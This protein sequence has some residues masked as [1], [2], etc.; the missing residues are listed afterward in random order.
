M[1]YLIRSPYPETIDLPAIVGG[2]VTYG[3]LPSRACTLPSGL[4]NGDFMV[5]VIWQMGSS[6]NV[7][8]GLSGWSLY[9]SY[10]NIH[11][12]RIQVYTKTAS[13]ESNPTIVFASAQY[14]VIFL[15]AYRN[16]KTGITQNQFN[17][18]TSSP[19]TT[20]S[21]SV[22]KDSIVIVGGSGAREGSSSSFDV[23]TLDFAGLTEDFQD[24][25]GKGRGVISHFVADASKT[26]GPYTM[27]FSNQ[28]FVTSSRSMILEIS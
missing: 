26:C 5:C 8:S 22:S 6:V 12:W 27:T 20:T 1:S 9:T 28:A 18:D 25:T 2:T 13:N 3:Y 10:N 14:S 21:A 23:G 15:L 17:T 11:A 19:F 24:A 16:I 4:Q 7:S